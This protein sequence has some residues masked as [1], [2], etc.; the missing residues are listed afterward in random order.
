MSAR[1]R[2]QG[3]PAVALAP[4]AG[5]T[6]LPFRRLV[7]RFGPVEVTSEMVASREMLSGR[8]AARARAEIGAE[9]GAAAV[10]LAGRDPQLMAE[11]AR[12]AEAHGAAR[13]DLNMGCPAKRVTGGLSGAALMREPDL[14]LAIVAAVVG[15]VRVPVTVKMRLGWDDASRNAADLA[16]RAEAAGVA[17]I[18]VH[19]RTR[20]QFY[21]GRADWAAVAEVVAAVR[22]P[23]LVNGDIS[24]MAEARAALAAS[25]AAG[26]MIGRAARGAP[27]LPAAIARGLAGGPPPAPPRG[28]ALAALAL[29]L[30]EE[31]LGFYGRDLG[32]RVARKHLGWFMDQ[33]GTPAALRARVL[34]A[35]TAAAVRDLLPEALADERWAA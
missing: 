15:A 6:D 11:A 12:I 33:A 34:T 25:G 26:V 8:P 27:W 3:A 32:L 1:W 22:V 21:A 4:M 23:V 18:A 13:I 20:A 30:H 2:Q 14:A 5:I 24:G 10:Q 31:L 7:R 9:A 35:A 17:R 28:A 16:R 29:E 19:A